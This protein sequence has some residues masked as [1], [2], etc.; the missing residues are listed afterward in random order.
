MADPLRDGLERVPAG[1]NLGY[2]VDLGELGT[3]RHDEY[4]LRL[5]LGVPTEAVLDRG[6]IGECAGCDVRGDLEA[7]QRW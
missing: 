6:R 5:G 1:Q 7:V 4:L 3:A 2:E